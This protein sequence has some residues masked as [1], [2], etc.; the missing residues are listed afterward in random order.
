MRTELLAYLVCLS[1][2]STLEAGVDETDGDEIM[3]GTLTCAGCSARYPIVR[4]VPRMN[5][6]MER[7]EDVAKTFSF[8]WKAH[9]AGQLEE[10]DTLWGLTLDEDWHYFLEA[11]GLRD[12]DLEGALVLDGGCGSGRLTREMGRRGAKAVIGIDIIDAVDGAFEASR[13]LANVHI[14][15][16]NI[17]EL[18]L[19]KRVFD[20]VWSNGVIHHTPDARAAHAALAAM[21]KPRG[22]L[23][24]WVYAKRFNPFRF[25]K[26]VLDLLRVTRLPEPVLMR[27]AKLFAHVSLRILVVWR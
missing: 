1:C 3:T 4:G 19:R 6:A 23:Y 21:V 13:D 18:P 5:A 12:D 16:A 17:F 8:E 22:L 10:K 9:H 27:I 20:L 26:D 14:V 11:T 2:G 15:Q 24:V 7:L 25:T